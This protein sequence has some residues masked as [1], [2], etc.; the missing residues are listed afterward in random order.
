MTCPY[1]W[2]ISRRFGK[3]F[4]RLTM[5][6]LCDPGLQIWGSAHPREIRVDP[7]KNL[8]MN[9]HSSIVHNSL[10]RGNNPNS[11]QTDVQKWLCLSKWNI[12]LQW[13][14]VKCGNVWQRG[15]TFKT[16]CLWKGLSQRTTHY[17]I[18]PYKVCR[19]AKEREMALGG[20]GGG[21]PQGSG[22]ENVLTVTAAVAARICMAGD[23]AP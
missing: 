2:T 9:V 14:P 22:W 15:W 5:E 3:L 16:L 11:H 17:M 18:P 1:I 13:K 7:H 23:T 10:K 8:Y 6:Q 4:K 20:W 12:V 19:K 21:D